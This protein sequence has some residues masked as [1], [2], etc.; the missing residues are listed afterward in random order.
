MAYYLKL[1]LATLVAFLIIDMAWLG[2]VARTF[3]SKHL[4]FLMAPS[5][6]WLAAGVFYLLFIVGILVFAVLPGLQAG[7]L[8]TTL[9]RAALFG[10]IAY[11]TYDLTNL[12]TI[13]DW[14]LLVTVV[15]M[16]WGTVLSVVVSLAG[17]MAGRWLG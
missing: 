15:D 5:P 17:Y 10:L 6:N 2:L 7:S 8:V 16:I 14:P 1:Y 13:R 4:G 12:A 9:W 11:A 3:Y